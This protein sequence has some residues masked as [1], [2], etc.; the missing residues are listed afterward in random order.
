MTAKWT[1]PNFFLFSVLA[2]LEI[3]LDIEHSLESD[4]VSIVG[5]FSL[6]KRPFIVCSII[7]QCRHCPAQILYNHAAGSSGRY[8]IPYSDLVSIR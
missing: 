4:Q 1:Q 8:R 7:R 3:I 2:C 6:G 5:A